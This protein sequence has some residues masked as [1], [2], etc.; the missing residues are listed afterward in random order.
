MLTVM[1]EVQLWTVNPVKLTKKPGFICET[2][3]S[4]VHFSWLLPGQILV[5][6]GVGKTAHHFMWCR[7]RW[8]LP[9]S[10]AMLKTAHIYWRKNKLT[11][12]RKCKIA[13]DP[14]EIKQG[15]FIAHRLSQKNVR[16]EGNNFAVLFFSIYGNFQLCPFLCPTNLFS[17]D[18]LSQLLSFL[19]HCAA[20]LL[21]E[22][23]PRYAFLFLLPSL[24]ALWQDFYLW[25]SWSC[26]KSACATVLAHAPT[27]GKHGDGMEH[28]R[29]CRLPCSEPRY[30]VFLFAQ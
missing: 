20:L 29:V 4:T 28:Q 17:V 9:R 2:I 26:R 19:H 11:L 15:F 7:C 18:S 14:K 13:K 12:K 1:Y 22:V 21:L 25:R 8:G 10:A 30:P 23:V 16:N 3:H 27:A 24:Q 6:T 5:L